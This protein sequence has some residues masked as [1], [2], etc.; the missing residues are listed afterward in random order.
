VSKE[1]AFLFGPFIGSLS[2]EM[3]RFAPYAIFLKKQEPHI[4]LIV[5]TRPERFDLYGRYA[6]I[7][8]PLRLRREENYEQ[9]C[10]GLENFP[11]DTYNLIKS[12]FL[13][14]YKKKFKIKNI[15]CPNIDGF[16]FR[17]KWQFPR[18]KMDYNFRPRQTNK[19]LIEKIKKPVFVDLSWLKNLGEKDLL[20]NHLSEFINFVTSEDIQ[21]ISFKENV[22][23]LGCIIETIKESRVVIGNLSSSISHLSILLKIKLISIDDK[24]SDDDI[25]LLN[26]FETEVIRYSDALDKFKY[27]ELKE[28]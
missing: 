19:E 1:Q 13:D 16:M 28:R 11:L 5:L 7:L 27:L 6:D 26:P 23:L 25:H 3:Y 21:K 24:M 8:V 15:F 20:L 9:D 22:S 18:D 17:V 4:K 12:S 2:W 14:Q 10:F